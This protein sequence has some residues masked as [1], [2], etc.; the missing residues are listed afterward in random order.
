MSSPYVGMYMG[1]FEE[2][3]RGCKEGLSGKK[4]QIARRIE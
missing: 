4:L 1:I 3:G 2:G